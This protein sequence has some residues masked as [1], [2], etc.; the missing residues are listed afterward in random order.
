MV[1]VLASKPRRLLLRTLANVAEFKRRFEI[2]D[3][4]EI[5]L[6]GDREN[7]FKGSRDSMPFHTMSLVDCGVKFPLDPFLVSF[8][9]QTN[10]IPSQCCPNLFRVVMAVKKLNDIRGTHL[11][12][13]EIIYCYKLLKTKEEDYYLQAR[14]SDHRLVTGLPTS[15]KG[16]RGSYVFVSGD[17]E[18]P[19]GVS[20]KG[21]H[22]PT[23]WGTPG[24]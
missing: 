24:V 8:L 6:R 19:A 20:Y 21:P 16:Y 12:L 9:E 7:A 3:G 5:R 23:H 2:P 15:N 1:V 11:G 13:P 14:D 4:V 18:F 17:W 22:V 10:L